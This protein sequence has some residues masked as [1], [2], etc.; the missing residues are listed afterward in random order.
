[1]DCVFCA[2]VARDL[3]ADVVG[4]TEGALAFRDIN[5]AAPVHVLLVPKEHIASSAAE[6]RIEH[7]DTLGELFELGAHVAEEEGLGGTYR[8]VTNSGSRAGQSVFHL[9]FHL[10]GGWGRADRAARM[11]GDETDG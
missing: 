2:I 11:P 5:P 4:E 3:P 6:L 7:G 10:L 1:M 8:L 9:H